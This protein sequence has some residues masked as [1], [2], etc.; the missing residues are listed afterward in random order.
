MTRIHFHGLDV[1]MANLTVEQPSIKVLK[2]EIHHGL[3]LERKQN[4]S[5]DDYTTSSSSILGAPATYYVPKNDQRHFLDCLD[6]S[7]RPYCIAVTA[8][9][10]SPMKMFV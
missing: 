4:G 10:D 7:R 9:I 1:E 5:I 3:S 8:L 2:V 6:Y